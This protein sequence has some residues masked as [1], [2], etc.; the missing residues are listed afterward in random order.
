VDK[1]VYFPGAS[2]PYHEKY[3]ATTN[4]LKSECG[5]RGVELVVV[6]YPGQ[7][8]EKKETTGQ[9]CLTSSV[10][11]ALPIIEELES[12]HVR[13]RSIG[14]S[15]GC[16]VT[17]ATSIKASSVGGWERAIVWGPNPHWVMWKYWGQEEPPANIGSGT[18]TIKPHELFFQRLIP[19]EYLLNTT[20][21]QC[22]VGVGSKDTYLSGQKYVDYLEALYLHHMEGPALGSG[23]RHKFSFVEGCQHNVKPEDAGLP[24]FL[25]LVFK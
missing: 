12:Q 9:L 3:L 4:M 21:L 7:I 10:A 1:L 19:V 11:H 22:T 14:I 18:R 20:P 5:K 2:S 8:D 23:P 16:H 15:Y 24:A 6:N 25:D 13:Y 17:L